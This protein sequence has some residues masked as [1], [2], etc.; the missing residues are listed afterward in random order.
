MFRRWQLRP[1]E[2]RVA[3]V[4]KTKKGKGTK[5]MVL[6][7]GAGTPLGA[8]LDSASP[9][10]V[11]LLEQTLDTVAVRRTGKPGR[12]RK[13][14]ERLIADRG[15]DSNPLRK[16]LKGRGIDPIIPAPSNNMRATDQ[17]GRKMRRDKRRWIVERIF[18]WLGH[19]RRLTTR[20]E[21]L[22]ETYSGFFHIACAL[23]TLKRV[24]K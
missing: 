19:F 7:D 11:K 24:L 8:Y 17:D 2:K 18:A 10:E 1:G 15:Y 13:R 6:V 21:R 12:P 20:H 16:A 9:S 5:W 14:S 22:I 23:L 3:C 4:G